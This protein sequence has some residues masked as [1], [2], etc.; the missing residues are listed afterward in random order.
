MCE[1]QRARDR[2]INCGPA[3]VSNHSIAR[4]TCG[5][6]IQ[7][8]RPLRKIMRIEVRRWLN[9]PVAWTLIV[10]ILSSLGIF[11]EVF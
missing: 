2:C 10:L 7:V 5:C 8:R 1:L 3:A 9:S 6:G 4:G 11:R